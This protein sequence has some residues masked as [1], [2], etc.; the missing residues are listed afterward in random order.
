MYTQEDV[1]KVQFRLLEMAVVIRD[2]LEKNSIPYF[3]TYGTLLGA[4]RHH[5]FIPWDDDFD[6]YLFDDTYEE[7]LAVLES[8]LPPDMFLESWYSEPKYFHDWAHVKD[9]NSE[10]KC[11]MYPHD[12]C[13]QHKGICIDLYRTKKILDIEEKLYRLNCYIDYLNRRENVGLIKKSD[14]KKKMAELIPKRDQEMFILKDS[15]SNGRE[16]YAFQ[17]FYNDRIFPEELFPLRN[18]QFEN[19]FFKGPNDAD[20]L[21]KRCYG[22]YMKLPPIEKR[23]PHYSSVIFY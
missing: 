19:E 2:I 21:L 12:G 11:E 14:Y 1:K 8:E 20:V 5:G 17:I 13:Y 10:T 22:D 16:M 15:K 3:I 7:A 9:E 4:V 18:Y 23:V 6:I